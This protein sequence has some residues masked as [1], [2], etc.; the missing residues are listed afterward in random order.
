MIGCLL[1]R[2]LLFINGKDTRPFLQNIISNDINYLSPRN[3]L[4]ATLLT[5]QG[6]YASDF[7]ILDYK[8]GVL[9]D[10]PS[11]QSQELR[12]KLTYYKLRSAVTLT[13]LSEK[14]TVLALPGL[15]SCR[16]F[17][18]EAIHGETYSPRD[19]TFLSVDPRLPS[20]GVRLLTLTSCLSETLETYRID[21]K[22]NENDYQYLRCQLG[23]PESPYDLIPNHT[24]LLEANLDRLRALSW[25]KGCYIGQEVTA[26]MR[27]RGSLKKRLIPAMIQGQPPPIGAPILHQGKNAATMRSHAQD[28]ALILLK[29][30]LIPE[31]KHDALTLHTS[32]STLTPYLP[33]WLDS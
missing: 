31:V 25:E 16:E 23:I 5:P 8:D 14:L 27:Y 11:T 29:S 3:A 22:P 17:G 19:E 32:D 21:L 2:S 33:D 7:F 10:L 15:E 26:R 30:H 4:Y 28:A 12:A 18:L 6:K 1:S 20:L 9:L 24:T 13:D